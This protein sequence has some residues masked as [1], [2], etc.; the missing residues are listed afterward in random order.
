MVSSHSKPVI[1]T[2]G[3]TG[4]LGKIVADHLHK[5]D[6]ISLRVTSRKK[7]QLPKLKEH[8][9]NAVFMD[10]DDPRTFEAALKD[11]DR[12]FL[13]TGYTVAM[14]VQSKA[15]VDAAKKAG[16]KHIVHLG[17]FT[18]KFD[19]YDLHFA[20][21]QLIEAYIKVSGIP[22][23]FLH[24]NCFMQNFTGVYNLA[25][26]GRVRW[27]TNDK[28][29]GWIALEDVGEA[30][31]K[32]LS[33]GPSKHQGKDYWFSTES[34]NIQE[35]ANVFSEATGKVFLAD[36]LAPEQFLK[37]F[38][39]TGISF[40]PYFVGAAEFFK[41]VVDGR[42]AYISDVRDDLP[43]LIGRKGMTLKDWAK[44]HKDE[45]LRLA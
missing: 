15:V 25:K 27:Y 37:D 29:V 43:S 4:Q 41:Q 8:Y 44:L 32:I 13:L 33:E 12:L 18:P 14:L 34:L 31:A 5:D 35:V 20:W 7:E 36:A 21:H 38:S 11:V 6:S 39:T 22:Y 1:L 16:V 2:L 3:V 10:L 9:G 17:V 26:N 24:P 23:T 19:C 30:A 42:M 40:D 28:K 45:L